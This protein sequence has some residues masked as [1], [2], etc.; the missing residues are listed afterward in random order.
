MLT[1]PFSLQNSK[2]PVKVKVKQRNRG[3][4]SADMTGTR[5]EER[6]IYFDLVES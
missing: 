6:K 5:Y 1:P 2:K 3:I 4:G